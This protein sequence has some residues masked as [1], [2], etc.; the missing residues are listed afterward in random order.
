MWVPICY[1]AGAFP[2]F[3]HSSF[4]RE[5][6]CTLPFCYPVRIEVKD[7]SSLLA[8]AARRRLFSPGEVAPH[9]L[10]VESSHPLSGQIG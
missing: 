5:Q 8:A 2:I 1:T 9:F 3:I 10:S 7:A 4:K 6:A